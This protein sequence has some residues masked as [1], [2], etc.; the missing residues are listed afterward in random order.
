M[1]KFKVIDNKLVFAVGPA[2]FNTFTDAI[3]H[4]AET[5]S[6]AYGQV[7]EEVAE[8]KA[9]LSLNLPELTNL[10][11][12]GQAYLNYLRAKCQI[13]RGKYEDAL[14]HLT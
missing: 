2:L 9:I 6:T 11:S 5:Q 10:N 1:S 13:K 12:A 7:F 3:I 14:K 8:G 4:G